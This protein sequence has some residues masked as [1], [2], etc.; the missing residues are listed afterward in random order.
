MQSL[1]R[2]NRSAAMVQRHAA[3]SAPFIDVSFMARGYSA[4]PTDAEGQVFRTTIG[5]GCACVHF[6]MALGNFDAPARARGQPGGVV[7]NLDGRRGRGRSLS[8][9]HGAQPGGTSA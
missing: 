3:T 4:A 9:G 6:A 5:T 7:L 2:Q 1:F 8:P